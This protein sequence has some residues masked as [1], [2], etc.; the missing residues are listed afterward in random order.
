MVHRAR[1][2][3]ALAAFMRAKAG[4]FGVTAAIAL[5]IAFGAGGVAIDMTNMVRARSTL[6]DA[7]DAA[8]LAASSALANKT[9][10]SDQ[11]KLV[12]RDFFRTQMRNWRSSSTAEDDAASERLAQS[13]GIDIDQQAMPGNGTRY[14]VTIS[15]DMPVKISGLTRMLG[16]T[17]AVVHASSIS[18]GTT[19][20][21][22]AVSMYLVLDRSGS[23]GDRTNQRDPNSSCAAG[24][25]ATSCNL[26]KINSL[27][28]AVSSLFTQL[29][30][31]DPD[32]SYV[33]TG[34]VS[35][36]TSMY[37]PS[38]LAWGT[39]T[40]MSYVNALS[41]G[42]NTDSSDAFVMAYNSLVTADENKAHLNKNGLVPK[43][44]IVFMTDGENNYFGK[45][46]DSSGASDSAT[47]SACKQAKS[48][49][50]EVYTVAFM[51][52][53]A[54]KK[55]LSS[56]ATD[57]AHFFPADDAAGL[58]SAF[59]TIGLNTASLAVTLAH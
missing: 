22:N 7:A 35:Y 13:L 25:T 40:A 38:P 17:D 50:M 30:N 36:S 27:K 57:A 12:A 45:N 4:N 6:Q 19:S 31:S 21:Q 2:R 3:A 10:S 49:G 9:M 1:L 29:K 15:A 53:A 34:A 5:P 33:R 24:N 42:G 54:G 48:A 37:T 59:K 44:T 39:A 23:M 51:A 28:L 16:A 8:A 18:K 52:P 55:L 41:A 32:S 56:C 11:A 58:M 43:K 14:V 26:T 46:K 47:L 20:T